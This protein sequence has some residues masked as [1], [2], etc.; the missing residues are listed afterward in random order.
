M[1]ITLPLQLQL[2]VILSF[3]QNK[4]MMIINFVTDHLKFWLKAIAGL[5][6]WFIDVLRDI[7]CQYFAMYMLYITRIIPMNT[8]CVNVC[9][10]RSDFES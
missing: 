10:H 2:C 4:N 8:S 5:N 6:V 7:F 9:I 1:H 3:V